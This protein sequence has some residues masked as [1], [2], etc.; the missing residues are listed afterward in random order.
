MFVCG[1]GRLRASARAGHAFLGYMKTT[2]Y[3]PVRELHPLGDPAVHPDGQLR[4]ASAASRRRCSA[5]P[6]RSSATCAAA[7]RWRR[8]SPAPRS[9]RSAARRSPPRPRRR[10]GAAGDA[11]LRLLRRARHRHA[12]RRRHARHPDPAVGASWSIYAILTE[13]NIAKLFMAALVPGLMATLVLHR[14]RS[15]GSYVA[16]RPDAGPARRGRGRRARQ[17]L[18]SVWPVLLIAR[19]GVRRHLRRRLHAD[20]G[21]RRRRRRHLPVGVLRGTLSWPG[22]SLS[23]LQTA[24]IIGDDLPDPARR[25]GVQRLPGAVA[26][27]GC[28]AAGS[29]TPACRPYRSCWR[30]CSSI[31]CS[32]R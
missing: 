7:W 17:A 26:A 12:R 30:C 1:A 2:P 18:R 32:A 4:R 8:S 11:A 24:E 5:P 28:G 16:A 25:R 27:A 21:R 31:S 6:A 13:Q 19:R 9:A 29:P 20:R 14:S 22:S 3:Y 10:G 23:L 15:P